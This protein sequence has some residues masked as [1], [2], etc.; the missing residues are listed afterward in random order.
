MRDLF[1]DLDRTVFI[2]TYGRSGSTLVQNMLNALPATCIRGENENL[3]APLARAWDMLRHSPNR[4]RARATTPGQPWYGI[5]AVTPEGFGAALARSFATEVL[6]PP[7]GTRIAGFKEIRWHSDPALFPVML[8]FLR[9][10]FPQ[11]Q[12]L[13]NLRDHEA[14]MRSGWWQHM[15]KAEVRRSLTRAEALYADYAARHPQCCLTLRYE[16]YVQS[17]QAWEPVFQFLGTPFDAALAERVLAEKL[18]HLQA[19]RPAG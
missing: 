17:A 15:P 6:R 7:P 16:D 13:F 2:V 3:L 14:V 9:D 8:D 1:P 12:F 11:A 5:E 4:Q 19:R 18:T 10:F